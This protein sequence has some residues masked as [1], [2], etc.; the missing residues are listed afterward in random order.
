MGVESGIGIGNR[1]HGRSLCKDAVKL[2]EVQ[3]IGEGVFQGCL[4]PG[5]F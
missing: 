4:F 2:I 1:V 3:P 5:F